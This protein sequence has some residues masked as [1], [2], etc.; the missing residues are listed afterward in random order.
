MLL[1]NLRK[2]LSQAKK[3]ALIDDRFEDLRNLSKKK[4]K[5]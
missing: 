4:N 3:L 2:K 1:S 5:E